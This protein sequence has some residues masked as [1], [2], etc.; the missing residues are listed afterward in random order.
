VQTDTFKPVS[1]VATRGQ[2]EQ[3]QANTWFENDRRNMLILLGSSLVLFFL[4]LSSWGL[5]DPGDGYFSEAAREMIECNDYIVPHLNYQIYFSKPVLIYWLIIAAY[6]AFGVTVFAARFWSAALATGMV[7]CCYWTT[8][9]IVNK[10]AG[11]IAALIFASAPLVVTFARMALIDM[12]F[13]CLLGFAMCATA[14][15]L[16][17]DSKRWWP[18]IYTSLALAVLD[19]G[20]AGLAVYL[21]GVAGFAVLYKRKP[22][23]MLPVLKRLHILPGIVLFTA[24]ALPWYLAVGIA[25]KG[26][27]PQVFFFFENV[28]RFAGHTNHRNPYVWFYLPVILYGFFPWFM[29]L[30]NALVDVAKERFSGSSSE[31][32]RTDNVQ[33]I[34]GYNLLTAGWTVTV[35]ILFSLSM[36]KLQTYI[37]PAFPSM[38]ILVGVALDRWATKFGN[39]SAGDSKPPWSFKIIAAALA[40]V[41][42][43]ASLACVAGIT[44]ACDPAV[45]MSVKAKFIPQLV[46]IVKDTPVASRTALIAM[47]AVLSVGLTLSAKSL[48]VSRTTANGVIILTATIVAACTIGSPVVFQ[49]GYKY[50]DADVQ[51]VAAVLH[52]RPG[53]VALFHDFKPGLIWHLQRPVDT[54]FSCDQ[55]HSRQAGEPQVQYIITGRKGSAELL[56]RYPTQLHVI[57]QKGDWYIFESHQVIALRLPTLERSFKEH[58]DLSGGDFSWGT[59]PFAGGTKARK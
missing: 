32:A 17:T 55:L 21:V 42:L 52:D 3:G 13:T 15:T 50:K 9:S 1:S 2:V 20:P 18:W 19:K 49:L 35:L 45:L 51:A 46:D 47:T 24:L 16:F 44:I 23:E 38:A 5:I 40:L 12:S 10:R 36:T 25:T 7:L 26:L 4:A 34:A 43:A 22:S 33:K 14:M 58:I 29:F 39:C 31:A 57:A 54:F 53:P 59:L 27:W 56:T 11:V 28:G 30:P 37:L 48:T 41:G 6:K 8:R